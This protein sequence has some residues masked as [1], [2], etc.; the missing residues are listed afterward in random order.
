MQLERLDLYNWCQFRRLSH[1]F[2]P[3]LT[4]IIGANGSGKSNI[5]I[6]IRWL[7]TGRITS[8]GVKEDNV[9]DFAAEAERAYGELTFS[10]GGIRATVKRHLRPSTPTTLTI[11]GESQPIRGDTA[12]TA[13]ILAILGIDADIID[14]VAIVGQRD[15]FGFL[16]KLPSKRLE[17]FQRLFRL[18]RA[19]EVYA[20]VSKRLAALQVP[21]VLADLDGMR[22]R[23]ATLLGQELELLQAKRG[24]TSVAE[25]QTQLTA[26][27]RILSEWQQRQLLLQRGQAVERSIA[28]AHAELDVLD[29]QITQA[30]ADIE[31]LRA[32][33]EGS[34]TE[35]DEARAMLANLRH[36]Q[37]TE[38]T[39]QTLRANLDRARAGLT[40]LPRPRAPRGWEELPLLA[41]PGQ[42]PGT[43]EAGTSAGLPAIC[44]SRDLT[45]LEQAANTAMVQ[46][47]RAQQLAQFV[48]SSHVE[49]PTCLTPVANLQAKAEAAKAELPALAAAW[50]EA[51]ARLEEARTY[52]KNLEVYD[53]HIR[54][55]QQQVDEAEEALRHLDTISAPVADEAELNGKVAA[56]QEYEAAVCEYEQTLNAHRQRHATIQGQLRAYQEQAEEIQSQMALLTVTESQAQ[57]AQAAVQQMHG[58]LAEAQR[59]ERE[60]AVVQ[61]TL[62]ELRTSIEAAEAAQ[63]RI[64]ACR[65]WQL[66]IAPVLG[67]LHRDGAPKAVVTQNLLGMESTINA[68]L[69]QFQADFRARAT[70]GATFDGVFTDGRRQPAQR[71]SGGQQVVL[72][73]CLRLA[74]NFTY[75]A[76]LG[77][78][79]LDEPT[80]HLDR[81]HV[82][83]VAPALDSLRR[84]TAT[85]GLQCIIVTHEEEL[86]PLFDNVLQLQ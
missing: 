28:T 70:D 83:G 13:R 59:V 55:Y 60:L 9:S 79:A 82:R 21:T 44:E 25:L 5:L 78:L 62:R 35:A 51:K 32:A 1:T 12:A 86:A 72:A 23:E 4:G 14:S 50:T 31:T 49:C 15:I 42:Q 69:Q 65:Q 26:Q 48:G 74:L 53:Q 56:H 71:L 34:R 33:R 47:T 73:F 38:R 76:D 75:A 24:L 45:T 36:Y 64:R 54:R 16:D 6:A 19:D 58:D 46:C 57:A 52:M 39:R 80:A 68:Y 77:F 29:R 63:R 10:H 3:G 7:L 22:A 17:S 27:Q 66:R 41:A 2:V 81:R 43:A 61:A 11:E 40:E 20:T 8:A 37:M 84:L 18:D 85:R 67:L 30:A